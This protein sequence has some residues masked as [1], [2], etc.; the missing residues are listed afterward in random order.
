MP[1][2]EDFVDRLS[3]DIAKDF[4]RIDDVFTRLLKDRSKWSDF[5]R[6]PNG[7]LIEMGLHPPTTSDAT[8]R[9]NR[10]FYATLTNKKLIELLHDIYKDFE[11]EP[12]NIQTFTEG[13][14]KEALNHSVKT[15]IKALDHIMSKPEKLRQC[16]EL[17]LHD[18]NERG[19]LT[20]KYTREEINDFI[21]KSLDALQRKLPLKEHPTLETWDDQ[22][23]VQ[24]CVAAIA[25]EAGVFGTVAAAAEAA[26]HVTAVG[27]ESMSMN[28][29]G[30]QGQI[31][32]S[33]MGD[34]ESVK[35]LSILGKLIDFAGELNTHVQNFER[36]KR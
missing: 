18:L 27:P 31:N 20:K 6:D 13:I 10:V 32:K 4:E 25:C 15:D 30:L 26:M 9:A 36:G 1:K 14:K 17:S 21:G 33:F 28:R 19:V 2:M 3:F 22:Y 12:N 34:E 23:G 24:T 7:T 5:F 11:D 29:E 16:Y 35:S 8:Q